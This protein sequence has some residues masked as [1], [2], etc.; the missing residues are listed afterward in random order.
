VRVVAVRVR[1]GAH[2]YHGATA[3]PSRNA[4]PSA[5]S[6]HEQD[7]ASLER[8]FAVASA[9]TPFSA[10]PP[11]A[12]PAL[13]RS[14]PLSRRAAAASLLLLLCFRFVAFCCSIQRALA[15]WNSV[16]PVLPPLRSDRRTAAAAGVAGARTQPH[17]VPSPLDVDVDVDVGLPTGR[18]IGIT[19]HVVH[20]PGPGSRARGEAGARPQ[21]PLPRRRARSAL[22]AARG[23]RAAAPASHTH[24]KFLKEN[25]AT[26]P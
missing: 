6:S 15:P 8:S 14:L 11:P 26:H 21:L 19:Y 18:G 3:L 22:A 9:S 17:H 10:P 23:S 4:D 16:L 24:S 20:E 25:K 13:S 7:V 5:T 12:P 2:S 1:L